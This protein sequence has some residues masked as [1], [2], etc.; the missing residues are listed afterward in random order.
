LVLKIINI[1]DNRL[2]SF[3]DAIIG[4]GIFRYNF[5]GFRARSCKN[6]KKSFKSFYIIVFEC[7]SVLILQN[8]SVIILPGNNNV[9]SPRKNHRWL[10]LFNVISQSQFTVIKINQ[11]LNQ[12]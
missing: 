4:M 2:I 3:R 10:L 11:N 12:K 8:I 5:S 7:S 9:L 6:Y 1:S